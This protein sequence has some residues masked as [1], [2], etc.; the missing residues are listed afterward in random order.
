MMNQ[1]ILGK[2][3]DGKIKVIQVENEEGDFYPIKYGDWNGEWSV[4]WWHFAGGGFTRFHVV[5]DFELTD[6]PIVPVSYRGQ[7][8]LVVVVQDFDHYGCELDGVFA[9]KPDAIQKS[10]NSDWG[11]YLAKAVSDENT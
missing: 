10:L 1:I 6:Y 3:V 8:V 4:D 11:D 9:L 2:I 7:M 5:D